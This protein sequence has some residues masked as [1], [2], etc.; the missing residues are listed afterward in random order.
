MKTLIQKLT[1]LKLNTKITIVIL[2][3]TFLPIAIFSGILFY[4]LEQD[5]INESKTYMLYKMNRESDQIATD[6]DSINMSTRFFLTHEGL[7]EVLNLAYD[8]EDSNVRDILTFYHSDVAELERL[9][10]NNP[11][12]YSVRVFSVTD[13]VQEMM[14]VLFQASR[15]ENLS[16][17]DASKPAGWHFGYHDQLFSSLITSQDEEIASLV[18]EVSDYHR[19]TVGYIEAAIRMKTLFPSLYE[20]LEGESAFYVETD[21]TY[22]ISKGIAYEP[23]ELVEVLKD[24]QPV[25]S[26]ENGDVYFVRK[27][28]RSYTVAVQP[29][30]AFGGTLYDVQDISDDIGNISH[31]RNVFVG[32]AVLMLFLSALGIDRIVRAMLRQFYGILDGIH[33]VQK[34][35]LSVRV[36]GH[37][38]DEMGELG[39]QLNK[40][41]DRIQTLMKSN[42]Q[43]EVLVKNSE[44]RTLQNQINAHFIYN[45]LESIKMMAEIDE[46]YEIADAITSLGKLLRYS[47]RWISGNV[48]LAEEV[49]YIRNYVLLMNLRYDFEV[50]LSIDIPEEL[51]DQEIPKM[52]LQPVVEN[53]VLHG[54]EPVATDTT[55]YIK[56]REGDGVFQI[57]I[58]DAGRGMSPEQLEK[59]RETIHGKVQ[60]EGGSAKGHGIG[61]K[62]V[63]DRIQLSFGK[64]YG[65]EVFSEESK[66]TKVALLMPRKTSERKGFAN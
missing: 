45:V 1:R 4:N 27:G 49:E 46:K 28:N 12:L 33:Q 34:G 35:D 9:V 48:S 56:A 8:G 6:V 62:N 30:K 65:V 53:A 21:G 63:E 10:N 17:Y 40:M 37:G 3:F 18:T 66:Y 57:E 59:L 11:L 44:I 55:I 31:R 47:M 64:D 29:M 43:R 5:V 19:G 39:T 36:D 41:L 38:S 42:I 60:P 26:S 16:W 54:I 24:A 22:H 15:M 58:T 52:S 25:V 61:L 14:P 50:I 51:Y 13:D 7:G 23:P 2:V 20:E 32:L